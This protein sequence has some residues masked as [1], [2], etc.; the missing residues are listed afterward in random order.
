MKSFSLG[1]LLALLV[2]FLLKAESPT[3]PETVRVFPA[4]KKSFWIEELTLENGHLKGIDPQNRKKVSLPLNDIHRLRFPVSGE[5]LL[6][7]R[8]SLK[9]DIRQPIR[10][11]YADLPDAIQIQFTVPM[12]TGM[13][14]TP[15]TNP[16]GVAR[17]NSVRFWIGNKTINAQGQGGGRDEMNAMD[18]W[19]KAIPASPTQEVLFELFIDRLNEKCHLRINHTYIHS[20]ALPTSYEAHPVGDTGAVIRSGIDPQ[21][22]EEF[23]VYSWTPTR[24][25]EQKESPHEKSDTLRLQNGDVLYGHITNIH[26][27]K[28]EV[29]LDKNTSIPIPF[30]R[31][32][33]INF[34]QR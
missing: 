9:L 20:W 5:K 22:V 29:T 4:G 7:Y 3:P 10:I 8:K 1:L 33:E 30:S 31:I 12:E 17:R 28:V 18:N 26:D 6:A 11:P 24:P 25:V 27:Q 14:F 32:R 2:P 21:S 23:S 19:T 15:L 16:D 34:T 13:Y